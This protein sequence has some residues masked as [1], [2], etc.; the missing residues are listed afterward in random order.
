MP[1][2]TDGHE[3]REQQLDAII[4]E[5][6]RSVETGRAPKQNEFIAQHPDFR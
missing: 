6:Y 4:A 2:S 5:Y 3:E 1:D